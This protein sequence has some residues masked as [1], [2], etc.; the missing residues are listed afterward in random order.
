M[1]LHRKLKKLCEDFNSKYNTELSFGIGVDGGAIWEKR[2]RN[3]NAP[4]KINYVGQINIASRI[5]STPYT[6]IKSSPANKATFPI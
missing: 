3:T 5:Y 2:I 4:D 6:N 1:V